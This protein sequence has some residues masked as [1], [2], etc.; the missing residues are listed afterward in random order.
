MSI[1]YWL[2]QEKQGQGIITLC[3][4]FFIDYAFKVLELNKVLISAAVGN[5]KS[6][7]ICE[8]LGLKNEGIDREGEFLYGQYVDLVRYSMLRKEWIVQ[9]NKI[10]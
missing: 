1:G 3:V 8:R 2:T 6:R 10:S 9:D 4:K 7:A 5:S